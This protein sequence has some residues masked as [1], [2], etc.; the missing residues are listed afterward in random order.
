MRIALGFDAASA[1]LSGIPRY[2]TRLAAE[3]ARAPE[4]DDL[5]LMTGFRVS[6]A[7]ATGVDPPSPAPQPRLSTRLR[8]GLGRHLVATPF[9]R[10]MTVALR[11]IPLE[12]HLRVAGIDLVH[13]PNYMT[14]GLRLPTVVT[15]HDM[16]VYDAPGTHPA[17]RV[18]WF[19]REIPRSIAYA[20]RIITLSAFSRDALVRRFP[21]TLGLIDVIPVGL[22][23]AFRPRTEAEAGGTIAKHGLTWRGY[24]LFVGTLEPRKNLDGVLTAFERMAAGASCPLA[25]VGAGGWSNDQLLARLA[26]AQARGFARR[27]GHVPDAELIDLF[28]GARG[29]VFPSLYEG[30]GLPALEAAACGTPVL[31]SINS[32]MASAL[33][34]L[35]LLVDPRAPDDLAA[36]LAVLASDPHLLPRAGEHADRIRAQFSWKRCV[37]D[38]LE[39]YR[40]ALATGTGKEHQSD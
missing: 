25:V 4:V 21:Q 29:L 26:S 5:V 33:G 37:D 22:D 1:P 24:L 28:A 23:E 8:Q 20:R 10:D 3:F 30:Q 15:I 17:N 34:D 7:P 14:R 19:Q 16:S 39:T 27:L 35:A 13:E 31:T 38:T 36:G 2:V 12:Q 18:A 11:R 40:R 9:V 32:P 6:P